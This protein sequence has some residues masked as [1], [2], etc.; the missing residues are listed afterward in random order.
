VPRDS[1]ATRRRILSAAVDEFAANGFAG[2]RVKRIATASEA[3]QRS[4]YVYF[5][6]KDGLFQA[7]MHHAITALNE[8]VPLS[9]DDLPGYAGRMFDYHI[10]HPQAL[11]M[12][13]WRHLERPEYGP[14][15][16]DLYAQKV[17][18]VRRSQILGSDR[19]I[20]PVDL[21]VLVAGLADSWLTSP[22]DLTAADGRNPQSS[23][24]LGA[25][26]AAVVEAAR[27]IVGG[28][29]TSSPESGHAT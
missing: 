13:M 5:G 9:E 4:I 19:P 15:F 2:G 26:R 7:A 20:P 14:D 28:D 10:K 22:S 21:I 24:R 3:N 25:H 16:G 29:T 23:R 27:R 18:A 8:A 17:R 6:D 11:R 1:T 12:S